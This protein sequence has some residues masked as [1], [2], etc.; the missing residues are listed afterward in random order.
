MDPDVSELHAMANKKAKDVRERLDRYENWRRIISENINDHLEYA[1]VS[2]ELKDIK[3]II[4]EEEGG[5]YGSLN[6]L[7]S[8]L[9]NEEATLAEKKSQVNELQTLMTT[10]SFEHLAVTPF[11]SQQT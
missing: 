6:E 10:V 1:R 8:E 11:P 3:A 2:T 7:E 9:K 5:G 4:E